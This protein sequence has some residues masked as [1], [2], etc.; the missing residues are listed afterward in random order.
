MNAVSMKCVDFCACVLEQKQICTK[1]EV[2]ARKSISCYS[3]LLLDFVFVLFPSK[4]LW[5]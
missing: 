5:N 4:A 1:S 3:N 2:I